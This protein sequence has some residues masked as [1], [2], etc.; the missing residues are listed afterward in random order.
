MTEALITGI[1]AATYCVLSF[2]LPFI[3]RGRNFILITGCLVLGPSHMV[4]GTRDNPTPLQ[5]NFT[6]RLFEKTL[7]LRKRWFLSLVRSMWDFITYILLLS[8]EFV[9]KTKN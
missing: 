6:V 5:D 3:E 8:Y 9:F 2:P 1:L 7:S 4:S